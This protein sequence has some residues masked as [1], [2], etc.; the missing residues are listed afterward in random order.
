M[1]RLVLTSAIV[2]LVIL[3]MIF[4]APVFAREAAEKNVRNKPRPSAKSLV[5]SSV[6]STPAAPITPPIDPLQELG[7][8]SLG[9]F[10]SAEVPRETL[11]PSRNPSPQN[12]SLDVSLSPEEIAL[13]Q[14]KFDE[15]IEYGVKVGLIKNRDEFK[16][17]WKTHSGEYLNRPA[18]EEMKRVNLETFVTL[19]HLRERLEKAGEQKDI[20]N[21]LRSLLKPLDDPQFT[22]NLTY[23]AEVLGVVV[24]GI[25]GMFKGALIAGPVAGVVGSLV[26]P[27]VRMPREW[28]T[29]MGA[30]M[31]S[32]PS[33]W[34]NRKVATAASSSN[35][36]SVDSESLKKFKEQLKEVDWTGLSP[37]EKNVARRKLIE[38]AV[39]FF[40]AWQQTNAPSVR[41]G[42]A[43]LYEAMFTRP[44]FYSQ[45]I[46]NFD[47]NLTVHEAELE[48]LEDKLEA[49]VKSPEAEK[50]IRE[51]I[52]QHHQAIKL[53]T[54][55]R[56][57]TIQ[58]AAASSVLYPEF[59][60]SLPPHLKEEVKNTRREMGLH[61]LT[62][63]AHQL[64]PEN[65]AIT[66]V[67]AP[68]PG[69]TIGADRCADLY[70]FLK[71]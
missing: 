16:R 10:F 29:V 21:Y 55:Q 68:D 45:A 28:A 63:L 27:L 17:W 58:L 53:A 14:K 4:P 36:G 46:S 66:G 11:T 60:N 47:T 50:K 32:K 8:K 48:R 30:K 20:G 57:K 41:D 24:G 22:Q 1:T 56:K 65:A 49:G 3:P 13:F 34:L 40:N 12:S 23:A 70:N 71:R 37:E 9:E 43:L 62:E 38:D 39:S 26:E 35:V 31:F 44:I 64:A 7:H 42:R 59:G 6:S 54:Q 19:V 5:T 51:K 33:A 25:V 67:D 15:Y 2:H 69:A 52:A 18:M 61:K